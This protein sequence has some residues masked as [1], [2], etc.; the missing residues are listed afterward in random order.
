M[1][2]GSVLSSD[3]SVL[4]R[5]LGPDEDAQSVEDDARVA[6]RLVDDEDFEESRRQEQVV[7]NQRMAVQATIHKARQ[8]PPVS[9]AAPVPTMPAAVTPGPLHSVLQ[10]SE[11]PVI[12]T[13]LEAGL[14]SC[15][16][17]R[18]VTPAITTRQLLIGVLRLNIT[19]NFNA[20]GF[21]LCRNTV[22]W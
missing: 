9:A 13:K 18:F 12:G 5:Y 8:P 4:S 17:G 3:G 10:N 6:A 15:S 21:R 2:S 7:A 22:T 19:Q 16:W 20:P 1:E 14:W 11:L